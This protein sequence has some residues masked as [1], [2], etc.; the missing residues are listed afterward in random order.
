MREEQLLTFYLER[1]TAGM[2]SKLLRAP[3]YNSINGELKLC[4]IYIFNLSDGIPTDNY[5]LNSTIHN[6]LKHLASNLFL[7]KLITSET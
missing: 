7:D 4:P 3:Q 1:L 6:K 2:V 5:P